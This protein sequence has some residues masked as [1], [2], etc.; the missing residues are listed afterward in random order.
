[1]LAAAIVPLLSLPA[2]AT[3]TPLYRSQPWSS[4]AFANVTA[5]AGVGANASLLHANDASREAI[6]GFLNGGRGAC[7]VDI[8]GDGDDDIYVS[9]PGPNQLF[10]N[11]GNFTFTDITE[12]AGAAEPGYGMGCASADLDNDGDQD[13]I[14]TQWQS[15]FSLWRNNGNSTFTNVSA[16]AGVD[17]TGPQTGVA[18]ADFDND[19]LLDFYLSEYSKVPDRIYRNLGG[20]TF[21]NRTNSSRIYDLDYG[22]QPVAGDYDQDGLMDI[23]V[24]NDYG[25]DTLWK[26]T[27]NFTFADLSRRSGADDPGSGMGAAWVDYDSDGDLDISVTN[28]YEDGL[29]ANDGG[30]F[31]N[32]ANASGVDDIW[33]GWGVVWFDFDHDGDLDLY[34]ASGNVEHGRQW[35]QPNKLFRSDGGGNFTDVSEGSGADTTDVSR[36]LAVSDLNGDGY[37]DLYVLNVNCPALLLAS[38]ISNTNGWLKVRLEGT[39]S[40]RDGIGA[41]VTVTTD[42]TR[43]LQ[44]LSAGSSYL[45][46]NSKTLTFGLGAYAS[47]REVI[48]E[49]PSGLRQVVRAVARNQTI[50]VVEEDIE[51][52]VA[53]ASDITAKQG[54]RFELNGTAS[55]DNV[56]ISAY[57]WSLSGN[58]T[59][60]NS[61]GASA[62]VVLY[63][64]GTY[65]GVLVVR[66]PFGLVG[67]AN[68][69]VTVFPFVNVTLDAGPDVMVA[70][71]TLVSF[72]AVAVS[73]STPDCLADCVFAWD[74]SDAPGPVSLSG[75][76][77][78]HRF[79]YPGTYSV[80]VSVTDPANATASDSLVVRVLDGLSPQVRADVPGAVD[81][82]VPVWLD[83][84]N[85]TDNDPGFPAT[86]AFAWSLDT[87]AGPV[88]WS[89]VRVQAV[90]ADPGNFTLTLTVRDAV[91]NAAARTFSVQVA[92][93]TPPTANA[94]PDRTVRPGE[95][96][97]LSASASTDNDPR[98]LSLGTFRWKV[99]R[100]AGVDNYTGAQRV[101]VF[102]TPGLFR[103][104][105]DLWDPSGNPALAPDVLYV[106]VLDEERPIAGTGGDR[107]V[108]VGQAFVLDG[109]TSSDND[110]SLLETGLFRW[111]FQDGSQRKAL[112]G[113][114][115][116]YTFARPGTYA[117]R[118]TVTD[119][120]GNSGAVV[121]SLKAVDSTAPVLV[122]A[123]PPTGLVAGG[124]LNLNA[125]GTADNVAVAT[126]AWTVEGPSS[127]TA[128]AFGFAAAIALPFEGVYRVTLTATDA[129]G[130]Q[131][132]ATFNLTV[133][134]RPSGSPGPGPEPGPSGGPP[135]PTGNGTQT[136][137]GSPPPSGGAANG[138]LAAGLV[139]AVALAAV[140]A[141][142]WRRTRA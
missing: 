116:E 62:W 112:D 10:R 134:A 11:D 3:P 131:A 109:T 132:A 119:Q 110:P 130:N 33:V 13:M 34:I 63:A 31:R 87:P 140:A 73:S 52:P 48:V 69:T 78:T 80:A 7:M 79:D 74:L 51:P 24:A 141:F 107:E 133:A 15:H 90:F 32:V 77:P 102:A 30:S 9:G 67:L 72:R 46:S 129:S 137:G 12:Q 5:T 45:S 42:A 106:R 115:V 136:G 108:E 104:E 98:L 39:V 101:V 59:G 1:M 8:E 128:A 29:W 53:R 50:T 124:T 135:A 121:F 92:D 26:N 99:E 85:T 86:G 57:A 43:E 64:A 2:L 117:V 28:Y 49:W 6:N 118:L 19:G 16:M 138:A 54:E 65:A 18:I 122:F 21:E 120:S 55:T 126:V 94:G 103:V 37:E 58:G 60:T 75:P 38:Q 17:D 123:P 83:A 68:F 91:G 81:E 25:L 22:F 88:L 125:T 36:G 47:A 97:I 142:R 66:D 105:L 71:G 95:E 44:L 41:T 113:L 35:D 61:S 23:Y 82:D 20:L 96:F 56:G 4:P 89:G 70:E 114:K 40:N 93:T 14:S 76:G 100:W 84:T 111:E 127:F 139:V 27:G